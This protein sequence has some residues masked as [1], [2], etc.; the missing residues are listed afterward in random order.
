MSYVIDCW[1]IVN[2]M[3]P[4]LLLGFGV[5]G[6]FSV[7][8][9]AQ[10]VS[11]NLGVSDFKSIV[12]ASFFGV[13]LPLCSCSVIPVVVGLNKQGASKATCI[14]FL[15][16]TPQ[17]GVDSILATYGVLGLPFAIFKAGYAFLIGVVG[18][19]LIKFFDEE[20]VSEESKSEAP[21]KPCCCS[22][23]EP[24][25]AAEAMKEEEEK[26]CCS[27]EKTEKEEC[28]S[29]FSK[30]FQ[31]IKYGYITLPGDIAKSL[32]VGIVCAGLI[33]ALP[34]EHLLTG[35]FEREI[36]QM[37]VMLVISVPLYVCATG[38]LP[39][40]VAL[41]LKG[42]SPGAA[43]VLLIA[44]PATNMATITTIYNIFGNR[45][46]I[47][48]LLT[49]AVSAI[50]GGLLFNVF[51]T[52]SIFLITIDSDHVHDMGAGLTGE[53]YGVILVLVLV[54]GLYRKLAKPKKACCSS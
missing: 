39:I 9:S 27:S 43:L 51:F 23:E 21:A 53:L 12:K 7:V 30:A 13:P 31:A 18:G 20:T 41:V 36:S 42:L 52:N 25:V 37:L 32:F 40:A 26:S 34:I 33:S 45:S 17:T 49:T 4:Y 48:Y 3:A 38:S 28:S 10:W 2:E 19:V 14:S 29:I 46:A 6:L 16:S 24:E 35:V 44:G 11:R 50:L 22:S 15:I 54:L 47:I 5:A 8:L 1:E